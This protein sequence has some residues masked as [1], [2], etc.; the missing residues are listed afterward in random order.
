M[1][2]VIK[3]VFSQRFVHSNVI[4]IFTNRRLR[5]FVVHLAQINVIPSCNHRLGNHVKWRVK[6]NIIRWIVNGIEYYFWCHI[7][8]VETL[9]SPEINKRTEPLGLYLHVNAGLRFTSVC[10]AAGW[11]LVFV[12]IWMNR[13]IHAGNKYVSHNELDWLGKGWWSCSPSLQFTGITI[14]IRR[15]ILP[16]GWGKEGQEGGGAGV[17]MSNWPCA[18]KEHGI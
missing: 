5:P 13:S 14:L 17:L 1:N 18:I 8:L 3:L 10:V 16:P 11:G 12:W 4:R 7:I 9:E 6:L 2:I 15:L